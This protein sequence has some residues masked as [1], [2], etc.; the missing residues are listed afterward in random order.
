MGGQRST[1]VTRSSTLDYPFKSVVTAIESGT[2][3]EG[4]SAVSR[5]LRVQ[6][7]IALRI[8]FA[9]ARIGP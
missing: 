3:G 6:S 4:T 8:K 2:L 7:S 9:L 1:E 5:Q